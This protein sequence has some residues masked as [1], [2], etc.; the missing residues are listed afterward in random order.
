MR[1]PN[2][3]RPVGPK[4]WCIFIDGIKDQ[5]AKMAA[6]LR[7]INSIRLL[8]KKDRLLTVLKLKRTGGKIQCIAQSKEV[9]IPRMSKILFFLS[10]FITNAIVLQ[11]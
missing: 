1:K 6:E 9:E 10:S 4:L 5:A 2:K 3:A 11:K 8:S 7:I